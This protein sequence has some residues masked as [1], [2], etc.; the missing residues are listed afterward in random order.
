LPKRRIADNGYILRFTI[1]QNVI[2]QSPRTEVVE[3]L[4]AHN[5][6]PGQRLLRLLK[7]IYI[8]IADADIPD[9][10]RG[11]QFLHGAHRVCNGMRSAPPMYKICIEVVCPQALKAGVTRSKR[12]FIGSIRWKNFADEEDFAA[13]STNGFPHDLFR[14][15]IHLSS[16]DVRHPQLDAGV[17]RFK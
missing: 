5:L 6:L 10:P 7:A 11:Y 14:A 4:V 1:L 15:G 13:I 9:F 8:K 3:H 12:S 16:I 17:Q 2:F